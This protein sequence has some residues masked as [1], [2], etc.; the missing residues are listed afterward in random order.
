M[1]HTV[2]LAIRVAVAVSHW[3]VI[4]RAFAV[5]VLIVVVAHALLSGSA[6]IVPATPVA[7]II[8]Q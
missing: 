2:D 6:A 3:N 7:Y 8:S 1:W 4:L 5:V